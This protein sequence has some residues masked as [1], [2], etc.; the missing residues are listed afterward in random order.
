MTRIPWRQV[1]RPRVPANQGAVL[2]IGQN[3]LKGTL[4]G[5]KIIN[6]KP[7]NDVIVI[8][9]IANEYK[10]P[11]HPQIG[12]HSFLNFFPKHLEHASYPD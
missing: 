9:S 1:G 12:Q 2:R 5:V 4:D 6:K 7:I 8:T 11:F 10:G 3:P